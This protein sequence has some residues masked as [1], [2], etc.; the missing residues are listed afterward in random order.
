MVNIVCVHFHGDKLSVGGLDL[1]TDATGA[2]DCARPLSSTGV[3]TGVGGSAKS[4]RQCVIV[5]EAPE[6]RITGKDSSSLRPALMAV[7]CTLMALRE[8]DEATAQ[9]R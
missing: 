7:G 1:P 4:C 2:F 3:G 6:S 8:S 5:M 9:K